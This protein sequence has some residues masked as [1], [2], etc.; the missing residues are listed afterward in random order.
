MRA[1]YAKSE[2]QNREND[3]FYVFMDEKEDITIHSITFFCN[4][5]PI[6]L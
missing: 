3:T 4:F 1:N 6:I 5:A 2:W